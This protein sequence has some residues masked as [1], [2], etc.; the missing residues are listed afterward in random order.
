M[1][2]VAVAG[3]SSLWAAAQLVRRPRLEALGQLRA[4]TVATMLSATGGFC[5]NLATVCLTVP[6]HPQ[7]A[8][9]PKVGLIVLQGLGESLAPLVLGCG[10]LAAAWL[11]AAVGG[12]R[13]EVAADRALRAL[14]QS[15][16]A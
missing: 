11:L 3:L 4:L 6:E 15:A 14:D 1:F 2:L 13:A 9:D 12:R 16:G 10:L 8:N 7:W 5:S